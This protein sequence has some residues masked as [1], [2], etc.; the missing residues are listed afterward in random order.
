MGCGK[1]A[2]WKRVKDPSARDKA[3]RYYYSQRSQDIAG[4]KKAAA[5]GRRLYMK[6]KRT[7]ATER[8]RKASSLRGKRSKAHGSKWAPF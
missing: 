3:R 7:A 2:W 6:A 5:E 1:G 8:K 4:M